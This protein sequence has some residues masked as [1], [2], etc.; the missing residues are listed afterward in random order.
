M[1][2]R[3]PR[4][5]G[6]RLFRLALGLLAAALAGELGLRLWNLFHVPTGSLYSYVVPVG[7][8]FKLRPDCAVVVPER[9][10][11]VLYRFNHEGYRDADHDPASPRRRIVW[12]GDSVSFGL[13]ITQERTFVGLLQR[14][15]AERPDPWE[16]VNLSIFAYDTRHEL[17]TLREDGLRHRPDLL[18]LQFY[19]ND[20]SL[21]SPKVDV[22]PP[23]V[24][25]RLLGLKNRLVSSSVL[26]LRAQQAAIGLSYRLFHDLRRRRF[27]ETLNADEPRLQRAYLAA[28][29][30]DATV[31]TFA[32]LAAI[33][34]I[35]RERQ[36]PLLVLI[37]PDETQLYTDRFDAI[38]RRV[39]GFCHKEGIA[40]FDPLPALRAAPDR[41][42]LFHDGVHYGEPG[43]ALLARLLLAEL[44]GRG[45]LLP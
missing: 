31:P 39:A 9:Y 34:R 22:P 26:Y 33:G 15:L 23:T 13:G 35:A 6:L 44:T 25:D 30:D 21:S 10:G 41:V 40:A 16:I 29:P 2:A 42:E 5:L 7:T 19:M 32:A 3:S 38:T 14:R 45:Y 36:I 12:L 37:S 20:F 11:D 8:R 18:V 4:P 43:H 24:S 27:P 1:I 28:H 17:E